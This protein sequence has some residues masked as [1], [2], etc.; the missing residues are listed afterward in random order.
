MVGFYWVFLLL[1]YIVMARNLD[2]A[3]RSVSS[4]PFHVVIRCDD[5][6]S[7]QGS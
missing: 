6:L 3:L 1:D 2:L 4:P 7:S 5:Y